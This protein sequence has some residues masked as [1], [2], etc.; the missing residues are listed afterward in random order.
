MMFPESS[1]TADSSQKS[2]GSKG[3]AKYLALL[4]PFMI[5]VALDQFTKFWVRTSPELHRLELIEGWFRFTY[6]LNPG[7]ALGMEWFPTPVISTIAIVATIGISG[8]VLMNLSHAKIGYLICMGFILGGAIGNIIDR[9]FLAVIEGYGGILDG[10]VVD[11]LH[12][13][14]QVN[15]V[16]LFPYIFNF[17]DVAISVSIGV[18]I[19]FHRWLIPHE[20]QS[21]LPPQSPDQNL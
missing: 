12:F 15:G 10:H 7:M 17:A 2:H 1:I 4:F 18:M 8:Y 16:S 19:L 14:K 5:T 6:T 9:L 11:F 20:P 3:K 21:E 13:S